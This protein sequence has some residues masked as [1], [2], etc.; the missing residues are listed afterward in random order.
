MVFARFDSATWL[1]MLYQLVPVHD[2]WRWIY[3]SAVLI[4]LVMIAF[5]LSDIE[6][7]IAPAQRSAPVYH[8]L[9]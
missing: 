5:T 8:K 4:I 1:R 3:R 6:G 2:P 9:R 7:R